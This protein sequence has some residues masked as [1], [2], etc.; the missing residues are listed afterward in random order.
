MS[1]SYSSRS[2]LLPFAPFS[3]TMPPPS[4]GRVKF[5]LPTNMNGALDCLEDENTV[6]VTL[7]DHWPSFHPWCILDCLLPRGLCASL[8]SEFRTYLPL[9]TYPLKLLVLGHNLPSR[10]VEDTL[11]ASAVLQRFE[12][13]GQVVLRTCP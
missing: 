6:E 10:A 4:S 9:D 11:T 5:F 8:L 1:S 12:D 3:L 13:S 2:I 7:H